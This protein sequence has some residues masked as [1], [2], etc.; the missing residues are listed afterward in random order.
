MKKFYL[1]DG[2][3]QIF[4]AYYA[5]FQLLESPAG[6]P[7]KATHIF[8]QMILSILRDKEPDYIGIAMDVKDSTTFRRELD[9]EYKANREDTPEDL[10][11]QIERIVQIIDL[12]GIPLFRMSG[13]EADDLIATIAKRLA[14]DDVELLMVSRDKDLYQLITDKVKLWDPGK[15]E[16]IDRDVLEATRGF[17]PEKAIDL[18]TLTGDSTD[19]IPGIHGVGVKKAITLLEKYG[20]ARGVI[21]H[22]DELTPKLRENVLAFQDQMERTRALV[23]LKTDTPV[24]FDL[25]LCARRPVP[26]DKLRP[27]F[28]EL[29][30]RR[31]ISQLDELDGDASAT[32]DASGA[33]APSR[34]VEGQYSLIDSTDAFSGFL[35]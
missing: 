1:I 4:R 33:E 31:L 9:P 30:F 32:N 11:P 8:T 26:T 20:D 22:A 18:Q 14:S 27:L 21:E 34:T 6:E 13:Y 28:E 5:P 10:P 2:H 24:E 17:S 23:T 19:N 16:L 29:G 15:D 7:I 35:T 25:E 12:F 3:A